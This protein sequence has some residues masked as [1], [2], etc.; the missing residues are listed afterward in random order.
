MAISKAT[1][2][3][4]RGIIG[5]AINGMSSS[6][7]AAIVAPE[8]FNPF[9]PHSGW[10]KIFSLALVSAVVGALLF[11]KQ[12]NLPEIEEEVTTTIKTTTKSGGEE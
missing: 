11:L 5:A 4:L 12:H 1:K 6:V 3:W 8:T 7:T 9:D 10:M 2:T